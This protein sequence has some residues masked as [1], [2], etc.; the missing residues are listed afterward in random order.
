MH[1]LVCNLYFSF[2]YYSVQFNQ[3]IFKEKDPQNICKEYSASKTFEKC[4]QDFIKKTLRKRCPRD[5][6]PIWATDDLSKVTKYYKHEKD[7][8]QWKYSRILNGIHES[9]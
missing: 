1:S 6:L 9:G 5:F 3:D 4:D 7:G 8:F 2:R